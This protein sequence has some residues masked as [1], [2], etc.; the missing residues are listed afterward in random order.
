MSVFTKVC[1]GKEP[2]LVYVKAPFIAHLPVMSCMMACNRG[3]L[4]KS[5]IPETL[6][7][8]IAKQPPLHS[9]N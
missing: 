1:H 7:R 8:L 2:L 3:C 6:V 5:G 9:A 4:T